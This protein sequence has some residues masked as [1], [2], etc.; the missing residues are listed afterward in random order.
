MNQSNVDVSWEDLPR[1]LGYQWD[2]EDFVSLSEVTAG[3]NSTL[4]RNFNEAAADLNQRVPYNWDLGDVKINGVIEPY[5]RF[6]DLMSVL[7]AIRI[8]T[9]CPADQGLASGSGY[10]I[11]LSENCGI[12]DAKQQV[13]R[14]CEL[15]VLELEK[16]NLIANC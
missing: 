7:P 11:F 8:E 15:M 14:F 12:A 5:T 4:I 13:S 3:I 6:F 16:I 1:I 10:L 2:D 9:D